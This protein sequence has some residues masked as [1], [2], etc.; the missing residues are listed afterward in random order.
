MNEINKNTPIIG[1]VRYSQKIKFGNSKIEKNVFE[2]EYFEYRYKIFMDVT[3][4]SFEDQSNKDFLLMIIHSESMPQ[5]YK[6]RFVNLELK[7]SFLKN[8]FL[9][10]TAES[11]QNLMLETKKFI[12]F[13]NSCGLTFRIDNDDAVPTNFIENLSPFLN[14]AFVGSC[15]N[16]PNIL[17]VKR[18]QTDKYLVERR[19]FPSNSMG[20]AY[21]TSENNFKTI[22]DINQHHL[23]NE[24]NNLILLP[25]Y[26]GMPIQTINGENAMNSINDSAST[27]FTEKKLQEFLED[28]NY[29][30]INLK[31]LKILKG[32]NRNLV[33]TIIS[34]FIPPI[35]KAGALK[36]KTFIKQ[37]N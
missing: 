5:K 31:C 18:A 21:V 34:L 1:F 22:F 10:D 13:K 20:L 14:P 33:K 27:T 36:M 9:Q 2:P 32:K 6:E 19:Y 26:S 12:D 4:K 15:I 35:I 28:H 37:K 23:V 3:L 29:D 11:L 25:K 16:L 24:N 17:I 8:Y 7:Y 30:K